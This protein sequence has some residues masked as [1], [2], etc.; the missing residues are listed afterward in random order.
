MP[1][2]AVSIPPAKIFAPA[3]ARLLEIWDYTLEKWSE[4]QADT[5]VQELLAAIHSLADHRLLWRPVA[6][7]SLRGI[8][9]L[10][11]GAELPGLTGPTSFVVEAPVR[12]VRHFYK[13]GVVP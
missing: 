1:P 11:H 5:Y 7:K 9:V 8:W 2:C 6:D 4:E 10:R 13:V 12:P 3:E